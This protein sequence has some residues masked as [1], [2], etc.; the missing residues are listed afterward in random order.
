[1]WQESREY[2][3]KTDYKITFLPYNRVE[4]RPAT[5]FLNYPST[6]S[7]ADDW[8]EESAWGTNK[9]EV[10]CGASTTERK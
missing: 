2:G 10:V 4:E 9:C 6:I 8:Q 3:E 5:I 1:M 7:V